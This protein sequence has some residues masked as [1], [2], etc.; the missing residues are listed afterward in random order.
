MQNRRC[1]MKTGVCDN[2]G[3]EAELWTMQE[4]NIG[5]HKKLFCPKCYG[6][7]DNAAKVYTIDFHRRR[8]KEEKK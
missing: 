7:A 4:M 3:E 5:R 2:C 1:E 6:S 8:R